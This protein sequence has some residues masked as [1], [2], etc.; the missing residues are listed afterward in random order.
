MTYLLGTI[1]GTGGSLA[2]GGQTS[3]GFTRSASPVLMHYHYIPFADVRV[4]ITFC[5]FVYLLPDSVP[6]KLIAFMLSG[7][8]DCIFLSALAS[9]ERNDGRWAETPDDIPKRCSPLL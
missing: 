7:E 5:S 3:S 4:H 6:E 2:H 9:Y 8:L 1:G